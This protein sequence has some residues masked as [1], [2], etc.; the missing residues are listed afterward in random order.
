MILTGDIG[1][2]TVCVCGVEKREAEGHTAVFCT[3]LET[4]PGKDGAA[5]KAELR[6]ALRKADVEIGQIE[7][8]VVSSVVPCLNRPI[9]ACIRAVLGREPVWITCQS[10]TGLK[11]DVEYPEKVGV[12]RIVDAAWVAANCPLPAV[13]VDLGTATTFNVIDEG[14]VFRGGAI[15]VGMATGLKALAAK[16]AQLPELRLDTVDSA[17]GKNT[18][19]CMESGAVIGAAAMIDGLVARIEQELG[20]PVTLVLTGGMARY[21]EPFCTHPHIY[22]P[23]LLAKGLMLLYEW[24]V[25]R[26][27]PEKIWLLLPALRA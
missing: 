8:A 1:N 10:K 12:D 24:N 22:D 5:Y 25:E 18:E 9:H 26:P 4:V 7:G 16:T 2:T 13:T 19:A 14:G 20:K 3:K 21:A 6:D 23:Q 15:A 11:M 27:A 17:I